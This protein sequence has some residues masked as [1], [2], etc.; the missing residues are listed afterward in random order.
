MAAVQPSALGAALLAQGFVTGTQLEQALAASEP[1]GL[2]LGD[3]LVALGYVSRAEIAAVLAQRGW[4]LL[5]PD[6]G[7]AQPG[8]HDAEDL[9][10]A[11]LDRVTQIK[12]AALPVPEEPATDFLAVVERAHRHLAVRRAQLAKRAASAVTPL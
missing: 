10:S 12:T 6:D 9:S 3:A 2:P 7:I 1:S 11:L 5:E 4:L 8:A